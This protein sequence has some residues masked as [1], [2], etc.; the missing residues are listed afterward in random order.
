MFASF[1][2]IAMPRI[3]AGLDEA[4]RA[5][6]F[7]A[8]AAALLTARL[9]HAALVSGRFL[10]TSHSAIMP[11]MVTPREHVARAHF[12]KVPRQQHVSST[13]MARC[14]IDG[15]YMLFTFLASPPPRSADIFRQVLIFS[16][17]SDGLYMMYC[18]Y[19]I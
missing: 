2:A 11:M 10:F 13:F 19:D 3:L 16:S 6:D 12:H 17:D 14:R 9:R 15:Q 18:L 4:L 8:A 7:R 1:A 5:A